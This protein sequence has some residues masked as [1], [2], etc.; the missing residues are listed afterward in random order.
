[1]PS[2]AIGWVP[3]SQRGDIITGSVYIRAGNAGLD[4]DYKIVNGL[5]GTIHKAFAVNT[6]FHELFIHLIRPKNLTTDDHV[7]N[8]ELVGSVSSRTSRPLKDD[9][10]VNNTA[11]PNA[12]TK[13]TGELA[14]WQLSRVLG[15]I[16]FGQ[17][18][19]TVNP[20]IIKVDKENIISNEQQQNPGS[21]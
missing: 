7:S 10:I 3:D 20:D 12:P 4:E 8:E 5:N 15:D 11:Q 9:A 6:A 19:K 2:A 1:L 21:N 18:N 14:Q 16:L 17:K 13:H